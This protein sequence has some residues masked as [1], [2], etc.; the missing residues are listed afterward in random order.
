MPPDRPCT[1]TA[2]RGRGQVARLTRSPSR[3]SFAGQDSGQRSPVYHRRRQQVDAG[4][5]QRIGRRAAGQGRCGT[6]PRPDRLCHRRRRPHRTPAARSAPF[7]I[8]GCCNLT[9]IWAAAGTPRHIFAVAPSRYLSNLPALNSLI[10]HH[11]QNNVK[12]IH[13]TLEASRRLPI[14]VM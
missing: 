4:Q 12:N 10:S 7:S 3:S 11:F 1:A 9:V 5:G 14:Y 8:R 6:D 13:I 2:G